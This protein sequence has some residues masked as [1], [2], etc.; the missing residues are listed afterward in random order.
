VLPGIFCF[1]CSKKSATNAV[2]GGMAAR[3]NNTLTLINV[4]ALRPAG[5]VLG[6]VTACYQVDSA[7]YPPWVGKASVAFKP[8]SNK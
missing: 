2:V 5:L 3:C 8:N 7:F 1:F 6:W 4:V